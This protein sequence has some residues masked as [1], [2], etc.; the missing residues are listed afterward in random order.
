[1]NSTKDLLEEALDV[2]V[3]LDEEGDG[4]GKCVDKRCRS[5]PCVPSC[6]IRAV[7]KK[8]GRVR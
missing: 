8:A 3:W 7:L 1:M 6:P 2:L 4:H 5:A